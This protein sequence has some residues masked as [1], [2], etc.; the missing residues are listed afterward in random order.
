MKNLKYYIENKQLIDSSEYLD[1][2]NCSSFTS[3]ENLEHI[4]TNLTLKDYDNLRNLSKL[5][6]IEF[7]IDSLDFIKEKYKK[8]FRFKYIN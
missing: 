2:E 7:I 4:E 3:L 1:F 6:H 5:N 8:R